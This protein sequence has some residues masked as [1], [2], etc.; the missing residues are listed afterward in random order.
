MS[1]KNKCP[2]EDPHATQ[3]DLYDC[4][5]ASGSSMSKVSFVETRYLLRHINAKCEFSDN[6]INYSPF[7]DHERSSTVSPVLNE[8]SFEPSAE[9]MVTMDPDAIAIISSVGENLNSGVLLLWLTAL[10]VKF[11]YI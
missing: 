5:I 3:F 8:S 4:A 2:N 11:I 6:T 1:Y 9:Y 10:I 7:S